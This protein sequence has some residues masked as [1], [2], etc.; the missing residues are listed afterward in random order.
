MCFCCECFRAKRWV[1][2]IKSWQSSSWIFLAW[3][4]LQCLQSVKK[5]W[6]VFWCFLCVWS[7]SSSCR[8][9]K[10]KQPISSQTEHKHF[11]LDRNHVETNKQTNRC[12]RELFV[13]WSGRRRWDG[14]QQDVLQ[15]HLT[16]DITAQFA[17]ESSCLQEVKSAAVDQPFTDTTDPLALVCRQE[18]AE[19]TRSAE[20][21]WRF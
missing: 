18:A 4:Q 21:M 15:G 10:E 7:R 13:S 5:M 9:F 19:E 20:V 11:N 16:V 6:D 14:A 1:S 3:A 2:R 12:Q 17:V 8:P